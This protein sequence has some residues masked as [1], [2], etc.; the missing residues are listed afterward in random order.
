MCMEKVLL[1]SVNRSKSLLLLQRERAMDA[2]R[3]TATDERAAVMRALH[4][5][6]ITWIRE[7]TDSD[8]DLWIP[9]LA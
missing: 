8:L 3:P 5:R 7:P 4:Q 1:N 2:E 9:C 6:L